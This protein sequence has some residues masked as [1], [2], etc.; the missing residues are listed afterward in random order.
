[1]ALPDKI[2]YSSRYQNFFLNLSSDL[3]TAQYSS[4]M[5]NS[6]QNDIFVTVF[7]PRNSEI[8]TIWL[9][10]DLWDFDGKIR[11]CETRYIETATCFLIYT[12]FQLEFDLSQDIISH[13]TVLGHHCAAVFEGQ[14]FH[15]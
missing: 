13:E 9:A 14:V 10:F 1:M 12:G 15:L 2:E 6:N 11:R 5:D 7:L 8:M 4:T 3:K